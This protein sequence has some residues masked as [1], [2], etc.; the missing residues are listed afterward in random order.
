MKEK[1]KLNG[2]QLKSLSQEI[3]NY[4]KRRNTLWK[5][6]ARHIGLIP[7]SLSRALKSPK[8]YELKQDKYEL[9]LSVSGSN[10]KKTISHARKKNTNS[11][12]IFTS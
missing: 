4:T 11:Y 9:I 2:E 5:E 8:G 1:A 6:L 7:A 12:T 3:E 10:T